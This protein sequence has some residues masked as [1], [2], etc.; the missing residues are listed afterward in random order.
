MLVP[1]VAPQK[2]GGPPLRFG[3][4]IDRNLNHITGRHAPQ[5]ALRALL[6]LPQARKGTACVA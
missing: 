1:L 2:N 4:S 5:R 3:G 6:R